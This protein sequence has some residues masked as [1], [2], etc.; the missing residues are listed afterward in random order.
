MTDKTKEGKKG[1]KI[2]LEQKENK[3]TD[4]GETDEREII[5]KS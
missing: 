4:L 5:C 1:R 3:N 2:E